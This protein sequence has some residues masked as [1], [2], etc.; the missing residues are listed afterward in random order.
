M[1]LK[2]P[3]CGNKCKNKTLCGEHILNAHYNEADSKVIKLLKCNIQQNNKSYFCSNAGSD[4]IKFI[5]DKNISKLD[6]ILNKGKSFKK[7]LP[8]YKNYSFLFDKIFRNSMKINSKVININL[9][10]PK[11]IMYNSKRIHIPKF[12]KKIK[13]KDSR[14]PRKWIYK[15]YFSGVL[16]MDKY[17][18]S[19]I[20]TIKDYNIKIW[21]YFDRLLRFDPKPY[22]E[23][24]NILNKNKPCFIIQTEEDYDNSNIDELFKKIKSYIPNCYE[25]TNKQYF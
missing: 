24:Y 3:I 9:N 13:E 21:N 2:C 5:R 17:E 22:N 8:N 15:Y 16:K 20:I 4:S 14:D 7:E 10:E 18:R 11:K 12:I 25:F 1:E 6:A 19:G 23:I